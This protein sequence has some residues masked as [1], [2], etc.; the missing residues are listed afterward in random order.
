MRVAL[1][2]DVPHELITGRVEGSV[3]S[4]RELDDSEAGSDV[5]TGPRA[6]LD[7]PVANLIAKLEKLFA[8]ERS[9][10]DGKVEALES[11]HSDSVQ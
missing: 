1:V 8:R 2:T 11:I 5:A 6:N 4:Y 10:I 7:E 3:E 9:Q